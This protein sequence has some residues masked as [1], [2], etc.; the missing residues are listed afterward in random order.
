MVGS[1]IDKARNNLGSQVPI[2]N[3]FDISQV[4]SLTWAC[5]MYLAPVKYYHFSS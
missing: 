5:P 1:V 3:L 2:L 4:G